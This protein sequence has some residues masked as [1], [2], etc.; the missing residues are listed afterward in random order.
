MRS[1]QMS[2][3]VVVL[4]ENLGLSKCA[5]VY[6]CITLCH[7]T[8]RPQDASGCVGFAHIA[9][10]VAL[11]RCEVVLAKPAHDEHAATLQARLRKVDLLVVVRVGKR[12][13]GGGVSGGGWH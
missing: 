11:L 9:A 6:V 3:S 13:G 2:A 10:L 7:H 1:S 5:Y 12:G 8:F 4:C